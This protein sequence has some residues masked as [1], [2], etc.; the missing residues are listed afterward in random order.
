MLRFKA[1]VRIEKLT[2]Q[3]VLALHV[4][5]AVYTEAGVHD[6]WVTSGN[7]STHMRQSKHYF[8]AAVDLRSQN[9]EWDAAAREAVWDRLRGILTSLGFQVLF[10]RRGE[11]EEHYHI[12]YDP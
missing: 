1:N 6:T 4:A 10:E 9:R 7:D 8:G 11:P 5:D 2:P 12:E 3:V